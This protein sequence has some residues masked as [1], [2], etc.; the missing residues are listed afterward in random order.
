MPDE[1]VAPV[2]PMLARHQLHQIE[3]NFFR[4]FVFRETK[5]LRQPD[6]VRVHYDS[7]ILMKRI[8]QYHIAVL[9]PTPGKAVSA[10]MVSGTFPPCSSAIARIAPRMLL[11]LLRKK[12]VDLIA[13]SNSASGAS[14]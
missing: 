9:R 6:H 3:L 14:A 2:C 1:P 5:P 13:F 8:A 7:F 4:V 12:P 11:V 10:S